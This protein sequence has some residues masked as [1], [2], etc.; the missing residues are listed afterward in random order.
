MG[1]PA[2]ESLNQPGDSMATLTD[3]REHRRFAGPFDGRRVGAIETPV[4][5]YDLSRGGCF[6]T[7]MHEERQPYDA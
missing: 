5:I 4:R 7:S 2:R 1:T 3:R 6:I